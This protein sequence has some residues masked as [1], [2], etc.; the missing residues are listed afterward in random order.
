MLTLFLRQLNQR[1]PRLLAKQSKKTVS[2]IS[3]I[4]P[5]HQND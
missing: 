3:H 2:W 5:F 4:C 1:K